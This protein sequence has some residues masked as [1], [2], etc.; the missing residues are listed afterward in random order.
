MISGHSE[1]AVRQ[2]RR[3]P[4]VT[5]EQSDTTDL[6][7][8]DQPGPAEEV[9]RPRLVVLCGPSGVGKTSVVAQSRELLP[10]LYVSISVTTRRPRPGEREGEHYRFVD[11]RTFD[12][13]LANGQL[14]EHAEYA[15]NRYGTPRGPIEEALRTGRPALLEIELQGA[16][17]VKAAIPDARLVM[18]APPSWAEL[19]D[20]LTSRGT[21]PDDVM[22]RRLRVAREELS[23]AG[24]FDET[25]VNADVRD[26]AARLVALL[27][28]QC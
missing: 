14:L 3:L 21:E 4:K 2:P 19:V 5:D 26:A 20:R 7:V 10:E 16:R 11:D 6:R 18:L 13:L 17:Q 15:G 27:V 23:A 24:E 28:G 22:A 1:R 25:I 8:S 12:E 9:G